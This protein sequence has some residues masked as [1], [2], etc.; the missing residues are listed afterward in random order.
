MIYI[1]ATGKKLDG[2]GK[3][4]VGTGK[5]LLDFLPKSATSSAATGKNRG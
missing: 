1:N 5:K 3:N 4:H 2:T